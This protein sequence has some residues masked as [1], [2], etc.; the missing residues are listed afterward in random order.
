MRKIK[1]LLMRI[2]GKTKDDDDI[3]VIIAFD[4]FGMLI[5]TAMHI[6]LL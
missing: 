3:R 4:E 5:I 2:R 1:H 6:E